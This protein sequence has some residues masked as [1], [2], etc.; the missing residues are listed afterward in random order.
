MSMFIRK[1]PFT[2]LVARCVLAALGT[3]TAA[4]LLLALTVLL[5]TAGQY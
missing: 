2:D 1:H 4:A 3:G 5:L